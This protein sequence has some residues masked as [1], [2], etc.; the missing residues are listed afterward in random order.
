[1]C[2]KFE[3]GTT[4]GLLRQ[5]NRQMDIIDTKPRVAFAIQPNIDK[6]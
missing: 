4:Y 5:L 1:M 6:Q 3:L 2:M